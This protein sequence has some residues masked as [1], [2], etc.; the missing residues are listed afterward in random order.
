[1]KPTTSS[2]NSPA[3]PPADTH[4]TRSCAG[5][6][7]GIV[8]SFTSVPAV[9]S[10]RL[11]PQHVRGTAPRKRPSTPHQPFP[12][13][14]SLGL[15][16]V[17]LSDTAQRLDTPSSVLLYDWKVLVDTTL[18]ASTTVAPPPT[19]QLQAAAPPMPTT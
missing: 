13:C 16:H 8:K 2:P 5:Q 18:P 1:M 7:T 9:A 4:A 19:R 6:H 17:A 14:A 12:V 15:L 3:T 11:L 10:C